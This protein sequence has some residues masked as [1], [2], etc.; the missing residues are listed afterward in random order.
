MDSGI[1]AIVNTLN[2]RKYYG[3]SVNL[4]A[5]RGHHWLQLRKSQHG[6]KHLQRAW[7]K[8][9]EASFVFQIVEYIR[10]EFLLDVEQKY[11]N[12]NRGGYNIAKYADSPTKGMRHSAKTRAKMSESQKGLGKGRKQSAETIG[13]KRLAMM[14]HKTSEETRAKISAAQKGRKQSP[15][16]IAKMIISNTGRKQSAETISK[17]VAKNTGQRRSPEVRA[18]MSAAQRASGYQCSVETRAKLSAA[19]QGRIPP[20]QK[21]YVHTAESKLKI[22]LAAKLMWEKHKAATCG[23]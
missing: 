1:Y 21:G 9:G 20:F 3:S 4:N 14:G 12:K 15:E 19:G 16:A 18:K 6:N 22:S 11:L 7:V 17:R 13:K 23:V 10:P 2:G 8:Y 5:R